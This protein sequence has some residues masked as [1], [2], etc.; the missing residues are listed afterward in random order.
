MRSSSRISST[1]LFLLLLAALTL[2]VGA[3]QS[4]PIAGGELS[5]LTVT[6]RNGAG[7]YVMGVPRE[8][9][10]ITDEKASRPIEFFENTDTPVS[11]GILIDTSGS[12]QLFENREIAR[13]GPIGETISRFLEL[14]NA[15]N[16]YFLMAFD[17]TPR[18]LTDWTSGQAL[19]AQK[20][21]IARQG[22]DTSFYDACF[23]AIEKLQTSH[24]SKRALILITDGVDNISRHTF[25][26]LRV[27]L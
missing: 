22:N 9:F 4:P 23:A 14:S 15:S 24:Y 8:A 1:V 20:T 12:M 11:I 16:E 2:S 7:N 13:P 26:Q 6:V 3:Q 25:K 19:L 18:F 27:E 17:K 5:I 21:D 10:E